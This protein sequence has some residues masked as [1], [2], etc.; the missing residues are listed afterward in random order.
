MADSLA[1][2]QRAIDAF[3][4]ERDWAQFHAPKNLAMGVAIEAAEIMEHFLWCT[5]EESHA[6]TAAK[7]AE[8]ANEIGDVFIYLLELGHVL[9]IDVIEA[10]RDKLVI[11]RE[12]YPVEKARG[13]AT[14]Y[15]DFD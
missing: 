8:V 15:S 5:D 6:L 11:N 7:R 3:V 1:E 9:G 4:T 2:L 10:A 12:K 14:K 13:R